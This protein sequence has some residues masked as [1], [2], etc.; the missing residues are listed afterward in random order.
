M[1][2]N[3]H[4]REILAPPSEVGLLIDSL[5][6]KHD[7]L[8]P[9]HEWPAM[10]LDRALG[11][12]A[13]GGHGPIRYIVTDYEPGRK[14]EFRFI[15]PSGFNGAHAFIAFELASGTT[16]LKHE[17]SMSPK[18]IARITWPLFFRPMHDALIEECLD[19][20]ELECGSPQRTKHR[21]SL[22]T[23]ILR[24]LFSSALSR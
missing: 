5:A 21:R 15:G 3:S 19:L 18:W 2:Y 6:S 8:W 13:T 22:W 11:V 9:R 4:E 20:A 17:L 24:A 10:R 7:R 12:G 1:V 14:A 23:R 16:L